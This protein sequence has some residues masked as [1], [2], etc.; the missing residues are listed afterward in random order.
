MAVFYLRYSG[1]LFF[2]DIELYI[3]RGVCNPKIYYLRPRLR[4][5]CAFIGTAL[6][7]ENRAMRDQWLRF[8]T[9]ESGATAIEYA[10]ICACMFL[11]I[12]GAVTTFASRATTMFNEIA[13]NVS[14]SP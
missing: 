3:N 1:D 9:D 2:T 8:L 6:R 11:A 12:I 5:R 14:H 4:L 13:S 7:S 10:I